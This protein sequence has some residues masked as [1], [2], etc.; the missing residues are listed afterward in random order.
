VESTRW[1]ALVEASPAPVARIDVDG[2][3][4][5]DGV[6]DEA[7]AELIVRA[8]AVPA[9][10]G[11]VDAGVPA[12]VDWGV[13]DDTGRRFVTRVTPL[14]DGGSLA[15]TTETTRL[16]SAEVAL[17]WERSHDRETDLPN[18]DLLLA[19]AEHTR[20]EGRRAGL[21]L[22]DV[23]D[24]ARRAVLLGVDPVRVLLVTAGRLR[25]H[26]D[27]ADVASGA[28]LVARVGDDQFAVLVPEDVDAAGPEPVGWSRPCEPR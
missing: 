6:P 22:V 28:A 16:H 2:H 11:A 15:V 8:A 21:V 3:W 12:S 14:P 10:A 19:T 27:R 1:R 13:D 23:D 18:R 20:A 5:P 25:E 7:V 24:A 17:A 26:L 4:H 9:I